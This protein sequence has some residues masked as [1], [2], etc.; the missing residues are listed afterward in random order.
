[1]WCWVVGCC[2][3]SMWKRKRPPVRM[4]WRARGLVDRCRVA[5]AC[6]LMTSGHEPDG[7]GHSGTDDNPCVAL[8]DLQQEADDAQH[9]EDF[10]DGSGSHHDLGVYGFGF[11]D[12][13]C[14]P[15]GAEACCWFGSTRLVARVMRV[16]EVT[17]VA[18]GRESCWAGA[19]SGP[20]RWAFANCA[21]RVGAGHGRGCAA[22]R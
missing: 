19:R 3:F 13:A 8:G 16:M 21:P 7:C 5:A 14:A 15:C 10:N 2:W 9:N 12:A 18:A 22:A 20:A 1:M 11:C 4:N 6:L 17:G